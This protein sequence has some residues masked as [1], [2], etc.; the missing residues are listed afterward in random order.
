M[1]TLVGMTEGVDLGLE[2]YPNPSQGIFFVAFE[3]PNPEDLVVTIYNELGQTV[4]QRQIAQASVG[5][6]EVTLGAVATGMYSVELR[7][8]SSLS[9]RKIV[10][11]K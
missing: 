1:N 6:V 5:R 8:G 9:T 11:G 3:L 10:V 2:V 7:A 4:W